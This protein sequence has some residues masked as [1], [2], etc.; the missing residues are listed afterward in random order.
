MA[1]VHS[2]GSAHQGSSY[3]S[4]LSKLEWESICGDSTWV[5]NPEC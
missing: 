2:A 3:G 1:A 5:L 4:H